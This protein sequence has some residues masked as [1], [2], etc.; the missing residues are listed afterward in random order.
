M[1]ICY[2]SAS[3]TSFYK[4]NLRTNLKTGSNKRRLN[5]LNFE[6]NHSLTKYITRVRTLCP[7][8]EQAQQAFDWVFTVS[9]K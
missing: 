3:F 1:E 8:L 2:Y 6:I 4:V 5:K 9:I 7:I